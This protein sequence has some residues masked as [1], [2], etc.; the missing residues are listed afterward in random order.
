MKKHTPRPNPMNKEKKLIV[1]MLFVAFMCSIFIISP[2]TLYP[3]AIVN[4][5]QYIIPLNV[6]IFMFV[7]PIAAYH[8][9]K[10]AFK[11]TKEDKQKLIQ[12]HK[13]NEELAKHDFRAFYRTTTSGTEWQIRN[14][15]NHTWEKAKLFIERQINGNIITEK[16][17]LEDVCRGK[18]VIIESQLSMEPNARWRVM[19]A[20]PFGY[21]VVFPSLWITNKY[22]NNNHK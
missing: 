20:S 22:D 7:I 18:A 21:Q 4:A 8:G 3:T 16:H 15:A 10:T 13:Y 11:I 1:I 9:L 14:I 6:A 2:F 5:L 19:V 12:F 17:E